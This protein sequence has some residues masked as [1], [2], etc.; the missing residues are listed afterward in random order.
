MEYEN[1]GIW[2]S[3]G[4]NTLGIQYDDNNMEK[5]GSWHRFPIINGLDGKTYNEMFENVLFQVAFDTDPEYLGKEP[6]VTA[7]F[8]DEALTVIIE[9]GRW[10]V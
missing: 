9:K 5:D 3:S 6:L 2:P 7:D 1:Y 4:R 10:Y 8:E